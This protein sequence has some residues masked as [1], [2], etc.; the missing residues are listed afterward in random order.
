MKLRTALLLLALLVVLCGGAASLSG[1]P[2]A[3]PPLLWALGL[4]I[5][6]WFERWTY[7][8]PPVDGPQ[9]EKTGERFIDPATGE[10]MEVLYDP[11]TGERQY[12]RA[13]P[14]QR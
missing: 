11:R 12:R 4:V 6:I 9:W 1:I 7:T 2:Q 8:K 10:A 3:G 5:C 13:T 14:E